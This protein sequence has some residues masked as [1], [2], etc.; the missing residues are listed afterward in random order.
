MTQLAARAAA[1]D[2]RDHAL[3]EERDQFVVGV[4]ERTGREGQIFDAHLG[5]GL[6]HHVHHP[7]AVS[8]R[9]VEGDGHAVLEARGLDG[10]L[11]A[12]EH[13]ARGAGRGGLQ[14]RARAAR[15]PGRRRGEGAR[16]GDDVPITGKARRNFTIGSVL[17]CS[18]SCRA[19]PAALARVSVRSA[20][21]TIGLSIILPF[22]ATTPDLLA[23]ASR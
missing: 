14:Q 19:R 23:M 6:D 17:H 11:D 15:A 3:L 16:V 22:R 2:R 5:D 10:L 7:V 1:L 21:T 8:E 20:R 4:Q 12:F 9:V 13:L 18:A